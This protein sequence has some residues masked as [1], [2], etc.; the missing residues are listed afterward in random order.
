MQVVLKGFPTEISDK[1]ELPDIAELLLYPMFFDTDIEDVYKYGT[2]FHRYLIDKTP[3]RN[4]KRHI[5]VLSEVRFIGPYLR[6]CTGNNGDPNREWHIDC[7]ENEDGRHIYHEERDIVHLLTNEVTSMTEFNENEIIVPISPNRPYDEF[8]TY[9]YDNINTLGIKPKK[10]P[11]NRIV[12]FT[13]HLH[14]ATN[15]ERPEFKFMFRIVE[16]DRLRPP[17]RYEKEHMVKVKGIGGVDIDNIYINGSHITIYV[18]QSIQDLQEKTLVPDSVEEGC[19]SGS[20][21]CEVDNSPKMTELVID[22]LA[23]E[24]NAVSPNNP[25]YNFTPNNSIMLISNRNFK[26]YTENMMFRQFLNDVDRYV[27]LVSED[28]EK[29]T[30][31]TFK[32]FFDDSERP[33]AGTF[34]YLSDEQAEKVKSGKVFSIHFHEHANVKFVLKEGL[35]FKYPQGSYYETETNTVKTQQQ[36]KVTVIDNL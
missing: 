13:N 3:L 9:I 27:Q 20:S 5:S 30:T 26:N 2:D 12:T 6:S 32:G 25:L 8:I 4:T 14:R 21:Q 33:M 28:G 18:P 16:T 19:C 15:P 31:C 7:E 34:I 29:I 11:A 24:T 1:I 10:M 22:E 36:S 17:S 35:K 23:W